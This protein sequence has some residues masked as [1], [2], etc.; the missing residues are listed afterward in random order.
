MPANKTRLIILSTILFILL[1]VTGFLG[2]KY[3]TNTTIDFSAV[4]NKF[5]AATD[6]QLDPKQPEIKGEIKAIGIGQQEFKFSHGDKVTGPKLQTVTLDPIDPDK[7][8]TQV[9]TATIKHDSPVTKANLIIES[10]NDIT[11]Q[12]LKL[13]N[14]DTQNGTWQAE[15][16]LKDTYDYNYYIKFDLQSSSGNYSGG[17]RLR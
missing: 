15:L 7:N 8:S 16:K 1:T 2:F 11:I 5:Q 10:D 12:P 9:I 14:G 17:L 4:T 3:F 13:I 6:S